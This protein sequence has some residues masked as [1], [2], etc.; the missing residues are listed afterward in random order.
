MIHTNQKHRANVSIQ[1]LDLLQRNHHLVY[2]MAAN[3]WYRSHPGDVEMVSDTLPSILTEE[4]RVGSAV[5]QN[6]TCAL[7]LFA[8]RRAELSSQGFCIIEGF[9]DDSSVSLMV[10]DLTVPRIQGGTF[11]RELL[12]NMEKSFSNGNESSTEEDQREWVWIINEGRPRTIHT[13]VMASDGSSPRIT[14]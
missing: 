1:D 10:G 13:G 4:E 2:C 6:D 7:S 8:S 14:L 3:N 9:L 11:F 12:E 5:I